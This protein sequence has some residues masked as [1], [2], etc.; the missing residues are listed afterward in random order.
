MPGNQ[1]FFSRLIRF[2]SKVWL[3]GLFIISVSGCA[4]SW[5]MDVTPP[6][7]YEPTHVVMSTN[8]A[9]VDISPLLPPDP[10]AGKIVYTTNCAPCHG[11]SGMGDGERVGNLS[12]P[13][14]PL[15][16]GSYNRKSSPVIWFQTITQGKIDRLMPGFSSTL[17][18]RQRWDVVAYLLSLG[19]TR[20]QWTNGELTYRQYCQSCH[21]TDAKTRPGETPHLTDEELLRLSLDDIVQIITDGKK[22]MPAVGNQLSDEQKLNTAFYLRSLLFTSPFAESVDGTPVP[23]Q[24]S[25]PLPALMQS[26]EGSRTITGRVSNGSGGAVPADLVVEVNGF[27]AM[28]QVFTEKQTV[29]SD[30]SFSFFNLEENSQRV[31]L[32]TTVYK[33][34]RFSSGVIHSDQPEQMRNVQ[35]MIYEPISDI[36]QIKAERMHIFFEFPG[37]DIIRVSQLYILANPTNFLVIGADP[38][39]PVVNYV[40]PFGASNL[41]FQSGL[42]GQRYKLTASGFG[43]TQGIPPGSGTQ[44]LFSYDLPYKTDLLIPIKITIPVD[45]ANIMLPSEGVTIK[46]SQFQDLGE[47][48]IQN[49]TW[50]I[51]TSGTLTTGSTLDLL[52]SGKPKVLDPQME[53]LNSDLAVGIITLGIVLLIVGRTIFPKFS[54]PKTPKFVNLTAAADQASQNAVLDSIIALD[55]QYHSGQIPIAAYHE[56]R[57]ELKR[58][59]CGDESD[60]R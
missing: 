14:P 7:N 20:D 44:V 9:N 15:G 34:I 50:H 42:V 24:V 13:P 53:E 19:L 47:K 18:D 56:R 59:L 31:Y 55:D 21:G 36:S 30:G 3:A 10:S 26:T 39:S 5:L 25:S 11:M 27:D 4:G 43:D 60:G 6:P 41:Q 57:E 40:L 45:T 8:P 38:E 32:L 52:I 48:K 29:S 37:S 12:V 28:N 54:R 58:R 46:S 35:I 33:S 22:E 23:S 1:G 2:F 49:T 17:S 16:T 51:Y